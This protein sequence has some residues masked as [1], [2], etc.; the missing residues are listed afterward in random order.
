MLQWKLHAITDID[1][2]GR[3][4]LNFFKRF[5]KKR[6]EPARQGDL[7]GNG[8]GERERDDTTAH[9]VDD[10]QAI[11]LHC[12]GSGRVGTSMSMTTGEIKYRTCGRCS[13]TG[14]VDASLAYYITY[15]N[16]SLEIA[17]QLIWQHGKPERVSLESVDGG[18]ADARLFFQDGFQALLGGFAV[19]YSGTRPDSLRAMLQAAGFQ[20]TKE[21]I[22]KMS[23]PAHFTR[24]IERE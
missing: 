17:R 9:Q 6:E 22:E 16:K 19:G 5:G 21:D 7:Q 23:L 1:Q 8:A 18:F 2:K 3:I 13:G 12:N 4:V 24:Q 11:C 10:G 20:V 15:P 14:R